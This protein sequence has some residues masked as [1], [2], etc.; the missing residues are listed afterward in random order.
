[1]N[2]FMS[3][4]GQKL[5]EAVQT[6][7]QNET[8]RAQQKETENQP[9]EDATMKAADLIVEKV[10]GG[11]HLS[12]EEKEQGGPLVHYAFGTL[13]G[14]IYGGLAEVAPPITAG[15][16]TGFGIV[17]FAGADLFAVPALGLSQS[18]SVE[19]V[20]KLTSPMAAH[21]VYGVTTDIVRR[22]L[23]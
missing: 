18:A 2:E 11:R 1:M 5:Q 4:P 10:T 6:D 14:G 23:R 19:P 13:M 17:L 16:G 15:A 22:L 3:G 7:E 20:S 21:L 12:W 9:K 8:D